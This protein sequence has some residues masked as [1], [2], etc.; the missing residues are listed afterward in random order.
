VGGMDKWCSRPQAAE[1]K[2]R[3]KEYFKFKNLIF[4]A[5]KILNY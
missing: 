3:K 5:L 1:S 2:E 4:F